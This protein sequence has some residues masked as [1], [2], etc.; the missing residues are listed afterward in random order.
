MIHTMAVIGFAPP[1]RIHRFLD[2]TYEHG[3]LN[4]TNGCLIWGGIQAGYA[5][6]NASV[7]LNRF[8]QSSMIDQKCP[9]NATY[10]HEP[11]L[12]PTYAHIPTELK[13]K[14]ALQ[15]IVAGRV[16]L[17]AGKGILSG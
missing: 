10:L 4:Q 13:G 11:D 15:T 5:D 12:S 7:T 17:P 14:V 8:Y 9:G 3:T 1:E 6:V 16:E 2:F